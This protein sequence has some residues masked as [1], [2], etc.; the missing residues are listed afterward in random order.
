M[1]HGRLVSIW[2]SAGVLILSVGCASVT[3]PDGGDRDATAPRLLRTTPAAKAVNFTG[4]TIK[5][6]FDEPVT[7]ENLAENLKINPVDPELQVK[8]TEAGNELTLQLSKALAPNTTYSLSLNSS[9]TDITEKTKAED[10]SLVFSTG[11]AVDSGQISGKVVHA[12]SGSA[13]AEVVVGLYD[14]PRGLT[15]SLP[16]TGKAELD[17]SAPRYRLRTTS[18]GTFSFRGL[19]PGAYQIVAFRD[20][21]K[22]LRYEE[23]ELV[24]YIGPVA[25]GDSTP[26]VVLNVAR[27]DSRPAFIVS[28]KEETGRFTLNYN[29]GIYRIKVQWAAKTQAPLLTKIKDGDGRSVEIFSSPGAENRTL[30]VLAV[31]SG[32]NVKADTLRLTFAAPPN[33]K[34][35]KNL[36]GVEVI[37]KTAGKAAVL[38]FP[39]AVL[40]TKSR[41]GRVKVKSVSTGSGLASAD[42]LVVLTELENGRTF[43][44]DSSQTQLTIPLAPVAGGRS[45]GV[46]YVFLDSSALVTSAGTAL[47]VPP[48]PLKTKDDK[49]EK[50]ALGV[51]T[52]AL[53]TRTSA[54]IL[55][56]VNSA[57]RVERTHQHLAAAPTPPPGTVKWEGLKPGIYKVRVRLDLNANGR[58]DGADPLFKRQPEPVIYLNDPVQV[59]ANWETE[60][61]IR[62]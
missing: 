38:T 4:R 40:P 29:E 54:Y 30:Y 26:A 6:Y 33:T 48:I 16:A 24:G 25:V 53:E 23:P 56:L 50:S 58:W 57:G 27:V 5:L 37:T 60:A 2:V 41:I 14:R 61:T 59:R 39:L 15:D 35:L 20:V 32:Y 1:L 3:P 7:V 22:N 44:L 42:S 34:P 31:D 18:E 13:V 47:A 28:R 43:T 49:A 55:E 52:L 51:L 11:S 46:Y 21:N 8:S 62:F 9:V 17:S 45:T 19:Q 10:I 36:P 12:I